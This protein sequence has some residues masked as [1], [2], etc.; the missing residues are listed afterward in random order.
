MFSNFRQVFRFSLK[1]R[2][3][4]GFSSFKGCGVKLKRFKLNERGFITSTVLL[5][6]SSH[7]I[8]PSQN[9]IHLK[10]AFSTVNQIPTNPNLW[11]KYQTFIPI[12]VSTKG[13]EDIYDFLKACKK[14]H[15]IEI[16]L[17]QLFLSLTVG[18]PK[19]PPDLNLSQ[20]SSQNGYIENSAA[21]PLIIGTIEAAT[22]QSNIFYLLK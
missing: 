15:Q 4:A 10:K 9:L 19:L 17:Q 12:K 2:F 14:E 20:I 7:S 16:P 11:V 13:C 21:H 8:C 3:S 22:N 1:P 5:K 18:G 6:A